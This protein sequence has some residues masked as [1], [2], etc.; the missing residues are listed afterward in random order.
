MSE[1]TVI[2]LSGGVGGAKMAQAIVENIE[3]PETLTVICNT[4]DDFEHLGLHIS[5]DLDSVMYRLG[6]LHDEERGWGRRNET[7][8]CLEALGPLGGETWFQLGDK[9]LATHIERTRLLRTGATLS[10]VTAR[11]CSSLGLGCS[12]VPM[13]D[14][15]VRTQVN[16]DS[17]PL[18]FQHYFVRE[19]C[20]PAVTGFQFRGIETA[21]ISPP[22]IQ[23]LESEALELAVL[24]PS[25]PYVS[26]DPILG[27][28]TF[29]DHLSA[30]RQREVPVV[31]I[32]PIIGGSA[33]KGPAAKMM[34]ELGLESTA[35]NVAKH[36]SAR[37]LITHFLIDPVDRNQ[38]AAIA[39]LGIEPIICPARLNTKP[40]RTHIME[41][42]LET[43]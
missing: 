20:Q 30:L 16:T 3:A 32:S 23:A 1:T 36:Y 29:E 15:S 37:S 35:L 24:C 26:M 21:A 4:A 41:A 33:L 6:S 8:H 28:T 17:G 2:A 9:D 34:T 5:P 11:L 25:N 31:A 39:D 18:D 40:A 22:C 19:R 14:D 43:L 7:W 42:I 27:L 12:V 10:A 38:Q 13:S